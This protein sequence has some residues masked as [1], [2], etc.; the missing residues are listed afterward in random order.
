MLGLVEVLV[1]NS[2]VMLVTKMAKELNYKLGVNFI[3]QY[4]KYDVNI[5]VMELSSS[6]TGKSRGSEFFVIIFML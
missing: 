1:I 4:F 3:Y 2:T 5:K 6:G